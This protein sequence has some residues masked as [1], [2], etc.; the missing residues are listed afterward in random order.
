V[1]AAYRQTYLADAGIGVA[2]ARAGNVIGAGDMAPNRL[3][4]DLVRAREEG[5]PAVLRHP[6]AVR[7][8]QYVLDALAG[9]LMLAERLTMASDEFAGPWNFGSGAGLSMTVGELATSFVEAFGGTI[10]CAAEPG[11][12]EAP[13]LRLSSVRA[14]HRLGWRPRVSIQEAVRWTAE[15]YERLLAGETGWLI[16]QIE[17][18]DELTA[19]ASQNEIHRAPE[20]RRAL[21]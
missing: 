15:G 10:V 13:V 20:L 14:R 8:W 18:Y 16:E 5:R 21:A 19:G 12:H 17:R 7:P 3:I 11:G 6:D 2:T 4:P 1:T 9:Y